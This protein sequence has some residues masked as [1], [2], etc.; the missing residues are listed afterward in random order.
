M[1]HACCSALTVNAQATSASP[2]VVSRLNRITPAVWITRA[3]SETHTLCYLTVAPSDRAMSGLWNLGCQTNGTYWL[4]AQSR[5]NSTTHCP[6]ASR[7]TQLEGSYLSVGCAIDPP[8]RPPAP[9]PPSF[10][11]ESCTC[12]SSLYVTAAE[13]E[14]VV[15]SK[16]ILPFL[17]KSATSA[18]QLEQLLSTN[19]QFPGHWLLECWASQEAQAARLTPTRLLRSIRPA[20][21]PA[22][23]SYE[24]Q[25]GPT[26]S[27]SCSA[28]N[29]TAPPLA[30]APPDDV[31]AWTTAPSLSRSLSLFSSARV[32]WPWFCVG[33][34]AILFLLALAAVCVGLA[35]R[36]PRPHRQASPSEDTGGVQLLTFSP[37]GVESGQ[38]EG[39]TETADKRSR[40]ACVGGALS[41]PATEGVL[42][43]QGRGLSVVDLT[44]LRAML[45]R[46]SAHEVLQEL[47]TGQKLLRDVDPEDVRVAL[48]SYRQ[49]RSDDDP[50]TLDSTAL[51]LVMAQAEQ[52]GV[53]G[54]WL[55]AWCFRMSGPSYNHSEFCAL[56]AR[57]ASSVSLVIWLPMSR[58]STPTQRHT[59]AYQYRLWCVSTA[60]CT[61][62][63]AT[64]CALHPVPTAPVLRR[65]VH[66]RSCVHR[67]AA[68]SGAHRGRPQRLPSSARPIWGVGPVELP[69]SRRTARHP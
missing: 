9:L 8:P 12:C 34:L 53:D 44:L 66:I 4:E 55:D 46:S 40:W 1:P 69:R 54:L 23:T 65:Q 15:L 37:T 31:Y 64:P 48:V 24:T 39:E 33:P 13:L 45:Q 58:P 7:W 21:C 29:S 38:G 57:V 25:E 22:H 6:A 63:S 27:V 20:A 52:A 17:Y 11:P 26:S 68:A 35:S 56:L 30:P 19:E 36:V 28:P 50:F 42:L 47:A 59:A 62:C 14:S 2:P 16:T 60:S 61:M 10:P 41:R 18:C 67:G 51:Q 49:E 3:E 32:L 5:D 43:H